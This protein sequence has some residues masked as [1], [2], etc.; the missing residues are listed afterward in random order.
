MGSS[1]AA[2]RRWTTVDGRKMHARVWLDPRVPADPPIVLVHGLGVASPMGVPV[3]ERLVA[4]HHVWAPDLPGFGDSEK[5]PRR[6]GIRGLADALGGWMDGSG[7]QQAVLLGV[8]LGCQVV[9]DLAARRPEL[10]R[11]VVL[12]SPTVDPSRRSWPQQIIRW[13]LEQTTQ[14][15]DMRRKML[16]GWAKA[17][18]GRT[19]GTFRAAMADPIEEKLPAVEAPAL[20]LLGTRDPLLS[21]GW[22]ASVAARLPRG[23]LRILPG[24]VHNLSHESPLELARVTDH[25]LRSPA[26]ASP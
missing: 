4:D 8:S 26:T 15:L 14:S 18:V 9:V 7:L 11:V 13:Q 24:A 6:L 10:V 3:A 22:A 20:V 21:R 25:F 2:D 17:G 5:P 16:A 23:E 12:G 19:V 1:A